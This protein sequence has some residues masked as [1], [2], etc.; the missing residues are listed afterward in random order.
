M[1]S[2]LEARRAGYTPKKSPTDVE[3]NSPAMTADIGTL[4]G[5]GVVA[6]KMIAISQATAIPMAPPMADMV[7]ASTRN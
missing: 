4:I 1:G 2:S 7:A 3:T 6:F 5:S